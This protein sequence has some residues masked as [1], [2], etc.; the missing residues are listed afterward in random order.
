V[1]DTV[2]LRAERD[3]RG[4]GRVYTITCEARDR[5]GLAAAATATFTVPSGGSR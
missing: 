3:A 2:R 1:C 4:A 5:A